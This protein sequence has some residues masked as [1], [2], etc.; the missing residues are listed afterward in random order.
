M[1]KVLKADFAEINM[2]GATPIYTQDLLVYRL[3][4][5]FN[6]GGCID[7]DNMRIVYLFAESSEH[8]IFRFINMNQYCRSDYR[9]FS[10]TYTQID[11]YPKKNMFIASYYA[12]FIIGDE[13]SKEI[14]EVLH[15][16]IT[17]CIELQRFFYFLYTKYKTV[18][19]HPSPRI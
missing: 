16:D 4:L 11:L 2:K 19:Q 18:S 7:F 14:L 9:K 1:Y 13:S 15:F 5:L 3:K 12:Y 6:T 10:D 8:V 17:S